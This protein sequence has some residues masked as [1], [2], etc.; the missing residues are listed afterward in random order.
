M[1]VK[2]NQVIKGNIFTNLKSVYELI[3]GYDRYPITP[4]EPNRPINDRDR[5]YPDRDPGYIDRDRGYLDR[6]RTFVDRYRPVIFIE[7]F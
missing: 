1:P 6:D 3:S 5:G 7:I 4:I 2:G